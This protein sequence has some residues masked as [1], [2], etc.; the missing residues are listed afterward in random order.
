[1]EVWHAYDLR[2]GGLAATVS[3]K[4]AE[5]GL[6]MPIKQMLFLP[7]ID[8]TATAETVW[9]SNADAPWLTP[10]RML[11]YRNLY[12]PDKSNWSNWDASPNLAPPELLAKS[13][14]TWI[15]VG[16]CDIL[17]KEAQLYGESLKNLGVESEVVVYEGSTHSLLV[18]DGM[19][20]TMSLRNL[21]FSR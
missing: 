19:C 12:I 14:S 3:M 17:C 9:A 10:S 6:K 21:L 13:P 11:W 5:L 4:A 20:P 15:A 18:M 2:G 16:E 7:V 1:M 8:N